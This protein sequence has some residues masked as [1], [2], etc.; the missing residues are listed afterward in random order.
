MVFARSNIKNMVKNHY[1]A[2]A[3]MD[4]TAWGKLC[5]YSAYNVE[6]RSGLLIVIDPRDTSQNAPDAGWTQ[7]KSLTYQ[8]ISLSVAAADWSSLTVT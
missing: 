7:K 2:Q 6:G 4:D 1:L 8:Y 5:H 3:I